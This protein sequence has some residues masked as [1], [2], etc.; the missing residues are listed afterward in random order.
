MSKKKKKISNRVQNS[1]YKPA[2]WPNH[3]IVKRFNIKA[4]IIKQKDSRLGGKNT[5][6]NFTMPIRSAPE[7]FIP[8][9]FRSHTKEAM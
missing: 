1:F 4:K 9:D 8:L 5:S 3:E 2:A 6:I 7:F